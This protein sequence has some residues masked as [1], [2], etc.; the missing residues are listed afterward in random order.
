[1]IAELAA[2]QSQIEWLMQLTVRHLLDVSIET[3]RIIMGSTTLARNAD[4]WIS[5]VREKHPDAG[6]IAWAEV[7]FKQVSDLAKS[8]NDYLHSIFGFGESA[9]EAAFLFSH[10]ISSND[11]VFPTFAMRVKTAAPTP[12]SSLRQSRD[13]AARLSVIAAHVEW[14]AMPEDEGPSPFQRRLGGRH[15]PVAPMKP[16]R[17]AKGRVPPPRS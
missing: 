12:V 13:Q 2:I 4:I 9:E 3:A 16:P 14:L 17:S 15:P 1:M 7:A 10:S 11:K 8:R 5:T 6:A